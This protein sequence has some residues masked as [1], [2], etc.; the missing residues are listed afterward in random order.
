MID[1]N[2]SSIARN[3]LRM[4]DFT[5]VRLLSSNILR[6]ALFSAPLLLFISVIYYSLAT[7]FAFVD[8][9]LYGENLADVLIFKDQES[10]LS[11]LHRNFVSRNIDRF[12]PFWELAN[13]FAFGVFGTTPWLHHLSRWVF[14]FTSVFMFAAAFVRI[15]KTYCGDASNETKDSLIVSHLSLV[16]ISLLIY[17]WIF[18]PNSPASRLQPQ[19][20]HTVF[21]LG[22]CNWMVALI[23]TENDRSGSMGSYLRRGLLCFGC[24]G[25]SWSK[26]VNVGVVFCMLI[27]QIA[28][29]LWHRRHI[30][31]GIASS[32]L[33]LFLSIFTTYRVY[34]ASQSAGVG[35]GKNLSISIIMENARSMLGGLFQGKTSVLIAISLIGFC[36][37][38]LTFL[39]RRVRGSR[40]DKRSMFL[41][42]LLAQAAAMFGV[43]CLSY[44]MALRYWYP[45]IPILAI[46]LAFSAHFVLESTQRRSR[47]A[48][49]LAKALLI[50][51]VGFFI[52][53]NYSNFLFQTIVQHSFSNID[54][55]MI[56]E[57][58]RL[59]ERGEHVQIPRTGDEY[60]DKLIGYFSEDGFS[61]N[62]YGK[63]YLVHTENPVA[64]SHRYF[65][66]REEPPE[67]GVVVWSAANRQHYGVLSIAS[68]IAS[69]LQG[70]EPYLA[71]DGGVASFDDHRW[72]I[73]RVAGEDRPLLIDAEFDIYFD[74]AARALVYMKNPCDASDAEARFYLHVAPADKADLLSTR[75]RKLGFDALG[76]GLS[77]KGGRVGGECVTQ[78]KLPNYAIYSMSTGRI[79]D[80]GR[81]IW[82]KDF[83]FYERNPYG[84]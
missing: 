16:P 81:R 55:K 32:A 10:I 62:F 69:F 17:F 15:S 63:S 2:A 37:I 76:F 77:D 28:L 33:L 35:Y 59:L 51:F 54:E 31:I 7:P 23:L 57:V 21:F 60:E 39:Y 53:C 73:Y 74:R 46:C 4:F 20:L 49:A 65:V 38:L 40:L 84:S 56:R 27:F 66:T 36:M 5:H 79:T 30:R 48:T 26:E 45:L 80:D 13:G 25:L 41:F 6:W 9:Y 82:E 58:T 43:L 70:G 64:V 78:V 61:A 19:E 3:Y 52:A 75:S 68:S 1:G 11:W 29:L 72:S 12:R 44:G 34:I 83:F 42:F 67:G 14:H 22:L 24:L 8:D 50:S 47:Y 18:F 71:R